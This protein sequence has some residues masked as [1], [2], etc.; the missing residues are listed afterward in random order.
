MKRRQLFRLSSAFVAGYNDLGL[1]LAG[2]IPAA[3]LT[4]QELI[5]DEEWIELM[6]LTVLF[7]ATLRLC[8][9]IRQERLELAEGSRVSDLL[10]ALQK[11]HEGLREALPSTLVSINREY[12]AKDEVLHD[13]DEVALFP[14]VSGGAISP[15]ATLVRTMQDAL[16][17]NHILAGMDVPQ[18]GAACV[19]SGTATGDTKSEAD[20]DRLVREI[21]VRWPAVEAIAVVQRVGRSDAGGP[22]VM[23]ACTSVRGDIDLLQAARFGI[24][25]L[26]QSSPSLGDEDVAEETQ[27]KLQ[28]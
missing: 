2:I 26:T 6:Q 28:D 16:D 27:S 14:P 4:A 24:E 9:G 23:I 17:M 10:S 19:F 5:D 22:N 1:K 3:D 7:F 8:V 21:R 25:H 11:R 20:V 15:K 18:S 12:A 13:G